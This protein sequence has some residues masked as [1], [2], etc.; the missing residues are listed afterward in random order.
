MVK[1]KSSQIKRSK[2]HA[3]TWVNPASSS[4]SDVKPTDALELISKEEVQQSTSELT[5]YLW[6]NVGNGSYN[7]VWKSN[8]ASPTSLVSG[9]PYQGPWVLKYPIESDNP[10]SNAM[11]QPSRSV[12]VWNE[13]NHKLPKAGLHK[14]GWVA[15]FISDTRHATDEEV[16]HKLI[17]IYCEQRRII[18]DAATEGNFLTRSDTGEVILVDV[19]L[20]LKRSNSFASLEYAKNLENRFASYW[21][22]ASLKKTMPTTLEVTRNLLF[23]EDYLQDS[24]DELCGKNLIT[25]QNV[26][27]LT[28]LRKNEKKLSLD[29][30][31][32]IAVLNE[33]DLFNEDLLQA[34]VSVEEQSFKANPPEL[35]KNS[36]SFLF[37]G[38]SSE[39]KEREYPTSS[40][41]YYAK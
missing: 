30:F 35:V 28:W 2:K 16:A 23:L 33:S 24:M 7:R 20:A 4:P 6:T 26:L 11:N 27:S 1:T 8:F 36:G 12:R 3:K 22:N 34:L 31:K 17:E 19:D 32:Q 18:L 5:P 21:V 39:D 37:F 13:I 40:L 14:A 15:P 41:E 38:T 25:L 9:E 29:L 10:V